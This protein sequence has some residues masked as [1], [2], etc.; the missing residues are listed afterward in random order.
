MNFLYAFVASLVFA[1]VDYVGYNVLAV[2]GKPQNVVYRVIQ[3]LFGLWL[4]YVL[5]GFGPRAALG[6]LTIYWFFID[7]VLYYLYY[8]VLKFFK[9]GAGATFKTEVL[10]DQV[11]WAWWT[12]F[13]LMRGFVEGKGKPVPGVDLLFQ[14]A[15]GLIIA[16]A[17]T[18]I[19]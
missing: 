17:I 13:G 16:L 5:W 7:D 19:I 9:N 12:P 1:F 2:K 6:A 11:T 8:D 10:G 18:K 15:F 4:A 14:A 3:G